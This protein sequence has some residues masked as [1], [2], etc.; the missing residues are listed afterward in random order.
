[1]GYGRPVR[2]RHVTSG[3]YLG[4][5]ADKKLVTL[6]R[7]ESNNDS[8]V[9]FLRESKVGQLADISAFPQRR[10]QSVGMHLD[11]YHVAA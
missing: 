10:R 11:G 7:L 8:T 4:V 6:Y 1:M 5:T 2:I 9:F 3:R